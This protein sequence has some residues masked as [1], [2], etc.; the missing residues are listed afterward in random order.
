MCK[1]G[2]LNTDELVKE[3][4]ARIHTETGRSVFIQFCTS[5][6]EALYKAQSCSTVDKFG[7]INAC[8]AASADNAFDSCSNNEDPR[9]CPLFREFWVFNYGE[10]K[11]LE[12]CG[13]EEA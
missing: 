11:A 2:R 3:L 13:K 8:D 10:A 5:D 9:A 12:V 1:Y 7:I 4:E 6:D